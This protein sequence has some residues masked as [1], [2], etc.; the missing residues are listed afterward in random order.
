MSVSYKD[1]LEQARVFLRENRNR[2]SPADWTIISEQGRQHFSRDKPSELIY[3]LTGN[4]TGVYT[5]TGVVTS[6]SNDFS[7]IL[8]IE[9]PTGENEPAMVERSTWKIY[10]PSSSSEQLKLFEITPDAS[11]TIRLTYT[12]PHSFSETTST[13]GDNDKMLIGLLLAAYAA[14]ALS[15]DFLKAN[16]SNIPNDSVD[17]SQ[18]SK[19]M[20]ALSDILFKR[21]ATMIAGKTD[22]NVEPAYAQKDYDMLNTFGEEYIV[23]DKANR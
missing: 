13:I 14:Q 16:R 22:G 20:Q 9:S 23:H 2:L 1:G 17:F 18:K 3:D 7:Q 5:L 11:E 21:Y 10:K 8:T 6:W 19:D 4:G 15:A 12:A